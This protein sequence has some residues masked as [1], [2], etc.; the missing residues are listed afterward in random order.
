VR[1]LFFLLAGL[2]ASVP[3]AAMSSDEEDRAASLVD[4]MAGEYRSAPTDDVN[5][6]QLVDRRLIIDAPQLGRHVVYWQLNSGEDERL[7]RQRLL[8]FE[9]V[10]GSDSVVQTTWAFRDPAAWADVLASPERL[11]DIAAN[12]LEHPLPP[13]CEPRW[14]PVEAGWRGSIQPTDCRIWSERRQA[15][16][17]LESEILVTVEACRQAERGYADDGTQLFGTPP[18]ELYR[19]NRVPTTTK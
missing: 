7:Y 17:R 8:V 16:R 14:Q 19:L 15:W 12:E 10:P 4:L 3:N 11:D 9:A 5:V 2:P 1:A 13:A 18:G 6:P